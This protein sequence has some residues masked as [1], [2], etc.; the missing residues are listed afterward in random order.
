VRGYYRSKTWWR[1]GYLNKKQ[2]PYP[3]P[4][5]TDEEVFTYDW[6]SPSKRTN[7]KQVFNS[8]YDNAMVRIT[9]RRNWQLVRDT[10]WY[11]GHFRWTGFDYL[12]EAGYVHGGWPFRAFMGGTLDLAGFK[13]DLFYLYQSQW[14]D[15][16]MVHILPHWTHPRMEAGRE[17]PV[18][19]YSNCDEVELWLNGR[20]IGKD[21]PGA[22]WNEMQCDWLVPW[23]PGKLEAI[24]YRGG[25]AVAHQVMQTAG[26]PA[27][28]ELSVAG[29]ECPIVT[30]KQCDVNGVLNPYAENRVHY[31]VDGP[32][33]I[34]SLE[35]GNPVNTENN[36]GRTSRA[37]FFGLARCFLE[38]SSQEGDIAL[39]AGA[40]L[41]EKQLETSH[42][43]AIDVQSL[44][45][46]GAAKRRDLRV[47]YSVDGSEPDAPY[48]RPLEVA[49]GT[50]VRAAVDDGGTTLMEMAERFGPE[51]G[52]YWGD[53]NVMHNVDTAPGRQAEEAHFVGARVVK[54]GAGFHG[55]GYLDFGQNK[56]AFVE[57]YQGNDGSPGDYT[58]SIRYSGNPK[59]R[60]GRKMQ[61]T[62]NG[63]SQELF[64]KSTQAYGSDW[65]A[66]QVPIRLKSGANT[67]RIT[68]IENGGMVIDSMDLN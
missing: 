19:V 14:T 45:I 10:P 35:S 22:E 24:G 34:L 44:S 37:A 51:E 53:R 68:T 66:R 39:V 42:I 46:R 31:H 23:S 58:L 16:T 55:R 2:A 43:V 18:W 33:R 1:D 49:P 63:Q 27:Q 47:L 11:A 61:L 7:A 3:C 9:A 20:S 17:I 12:G 25:R 29:D 13:K 67:I 32:A 38:A 54:Q 41:G 8:S 5:L 50:T 26:A 65:K 6:I 62:V 30:V 4:D 21:R 40:I 57:W 36:F 48:V 52:I 56:G 64:F 15:E 59:G 60:Q 28:I